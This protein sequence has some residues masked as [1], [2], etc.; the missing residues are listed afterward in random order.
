MLLTRIRLI[1]WH[2]FDDAT[3][4][5]GNMT[6]FAGDNGSGKSTIIDAIQYALIANIRKIKFNAAATDSRTSRTLESYCRCKIGSDSLDYIRDDTITHVMLQ[7]E[8]R[9]ESFCAGIMVECY[10]E[11]ADTGEHLWILKNGR[12]SDIQVYSGQVFLS[13][14]E[15]REGLKNSGA[16][17][18]ASKRDYNSRLTH[19]LGVHRRNVEFNPYLEAVI[20]SVSFTPLTSV[21][22]FVCNYILEE[23]QVDISSMRE[24]LLNYKE[25]E[26]EACLITEKIEALEKIEKTQNDMEQAKRQILLQ[27]YFKRKLD[28]EICCKKIS[29]K[30]EYLMGI[31]SK[32]SLLRETLGVIEEQK[33]RLEKLREEVSAALYKNDEHALLMSLRGARTEIA[34]KL[35]REKERHARYTLLKQQS[36]ALMG[37]TLSDSPDKDIKFIEKRREEL[38]SRR[39]QLSEIMDGL[40]ANLGDHKREL[41]ELAKGILRYPESAE[42]LKEE[43]VRQGI[44]AWIFSDLLE[45]S[46][47][48]WQ[49]AV[50]GW[51]NT[52]RFNILVPEHDFRKALNIYNKMPLSIYGVGIPDLEKMQDSEIRPGSLGELVTASSPYARRYAAYLLGDVIMADIDTLRDYR[53]SVTRECMRYS[54]HTASR[55]SEKIYSRWYIGKKAREKRMAVL[56]DEIARLGSEL[57]KTKKECGDILQRLEMSGR[58]ISSLHEMKNLKGSDVSTEELSKELE[59]TDQRISEI[60][61]SAFSDLQAQLASVLES[62][63]INEKEKTDSVR[64]TGK[65]DNM[66]ETIAAEIEALG[67]ERIILEKEYN[68]F[69]DSHPD[70]DDEF[71]NYYRERV[72]KDTLED[73]RARYDTS[74]KGFS[75]RLENIR[76][77]LVSLK[78]GYN[79]AFNTYMSELPDESGDYISLLKKYRDTELPLYEEK[80]TRARLAAEKQFKD[81]F[82]SRLNEYITE[83]SASF[84]E[85]NH[86]LKIITFGQDQYSFIINE[87]QEKR[88]ILEVIRTAAQISENTGTLWEQFSNDEQRESIDRLFGSILQNDL[89]SPEV[90]E[91]CDYR[92]YFNYD[93]KIK[94]MAT[95]DRK[96]GKPHELSLSRVLREKSGGETQNPYYVAIAAS[97]Y[98]FYKDEPDAI[99]LVLFDE[100]FNKMDDD[101]IGTTIDFFNKIGM[102]VI[103][104]VPTE[105]IE[106]IAPYMDRTNLVIRR[107]YTAVVRD[108]EVLS[109]ETM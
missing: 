44:K 32:L 15:F 50:E 36:E 77:C 57:E 93:I 65:Y 80:I 70:M 75:T 28:L 87:K 6:L 105:K 52:Q 63:K 89:D 41:D 2:F 53:K 39:Y 29:V 30:S 71:E 16:A 101:R 109:E 33:F 78:S 24:N 27:E 43:L 60:D 91:L 79:R 85:I 34:Q 35:E 92:Q 21:D 4:D 104:A 99:R 96:T 81:H 64:E 67:Q 46:D 45:V 9:A 98:R 49:N 31:R 73:L 5:I 84:S 23:R 20:R 102:Q 103:T 94:Q 42:A 8:N 88:K 37:E 38:G 19:L 83:A 100:A 62:I 86:T 68:L 69:R 12:L 106:N 82:V 54:S 40:R 66:K 74:M 72:K 61:T 14:R 95:I 17:L 56:R 10:K 108:Y 107:N 76:G 90:R 47:E 18:C 22:Q 13:P 11:K 26:R 51:L 3:L 48:S 1:N 55:I 7:F 25:A 97:F 58:V 59:K